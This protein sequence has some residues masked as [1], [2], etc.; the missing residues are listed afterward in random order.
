MPRYTIT[1]EIVTDEDA[2]LSTILDAAHEAEDD[3]A[4][5]LEAHEIDAL[6]KTDETTAA[7]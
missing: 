5:H 1:F 7:E 6:I 2:D 4:G 3:L